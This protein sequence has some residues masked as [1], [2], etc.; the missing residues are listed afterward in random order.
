MDHE[1]KEMAKING[2]EAQTFIKP[3]K[4]MEFSEEHAQH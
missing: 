3:E 4:R 2:N 1:K